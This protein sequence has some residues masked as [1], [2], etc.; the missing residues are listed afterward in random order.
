MY[1]I[2]QGKDHHLTITA[3]VTPASKINSSVR[4]MIPIPCL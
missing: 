4:I 2:M 3:E 1:P